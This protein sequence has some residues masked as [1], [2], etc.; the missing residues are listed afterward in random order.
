[1]KTRT[2]SYTT[3]VIPGTEIEVELPV[4][5][6]PIMDYHETLV[7]ITDDTIVLGYLAHDGDCANPL[8]DDGE[9]HI[10]EAR[11]HGNTLGKYCDA[12]GLRHDGGGPD[13]GLVDEEAAVEEA[14]RRILADPGETA[15]ALEHCRNYWEQPD[16]RGDDRFIEDC[17]DSLNELNPVFDVDA[18]LREMW[19]EGRK[20]GTIGNR[21]AIMLDVY[22]H[23]GITFRLSGQG[24][25]CQFDTARGGAVW[26]PDKYA[27]D[28][29]KR[30]GEVYRKGDIFHEGR[31]DFNVRTLSPD[32]LVYDD[33]VHPTFGHWHQACA[34]LEGLAA[35]NLRDL[36][37][38][39]HIAARELAK[40]A[41][42]QY[43]DWCNGNCF[44]VVVVTYDKE[45]NE[46]EHDSCWGFVGDDYAYESL[47]NDYFPKEDP[48]CAKG[49]HSWIGE[50]G[51]L[52]P[53]TRC[54]RCGEPYGNP[55]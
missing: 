30:R 37:T 33:V 54:T 8:D 49:L 48:E 1:M 13:L 15:K 47:K 22:E 25:Q 55:D 36:A 2:H 40:D 50:T 31:A 14:V 17:L 52:P 3:Y 23:S 27:E 43:T 46:I 39:E 44:G 7:K 11:R 34:Y 20:N 41:A 29:I 4:Q 45:G 16:G 51:K 32:T 28:E 38:A 12:L 5:P 10:Y 19:Q 6:S 42:E 24:M 26:V 35:T 21:Y 53:D 18:L 9:G